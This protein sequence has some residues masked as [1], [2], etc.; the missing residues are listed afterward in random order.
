M[1]WIVLEGKERESLFFFT[2][3]KRAI[4]AKTGKIPKKRIF[5]F[6]FLF[7]NVKN[8]LAIAISQGEGKKNVVLVDRQIR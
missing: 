8:F 7:Q 5:F 3:K 2:F 6:C 1:Q 4:L